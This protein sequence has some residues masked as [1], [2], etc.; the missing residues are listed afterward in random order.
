M[1]LEVEPSQDTMEEKERVV[2]VLKKEEDPQVAIN[3][4]VEACLGKKDRATDASRLNDGES[5]KLR[6]KLDPLNRQEIK[7]SVEYPTT[8]PTGFAEVFG[9]VRSGLD[10]LQSF[11][12]NDSRKS[13]FAS[14]KI[15]PGTTQPIS[16]LELKNSLTMF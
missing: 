2:I 12:I 5:F 11:Q 16:G 3:N 6:F 13:R 15:T 10:F 9:K 8:R 14:M 1:I 4:F 7:L